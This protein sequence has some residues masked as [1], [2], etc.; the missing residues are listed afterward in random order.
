MDFNT[1]LFIFLFLPLTFFVYF[2]AA[3]RGRVIVAVAASLLFYAWGQP[4]NLALVLG[5]LLLTF[6]IAKRAAAPR[7]L[8]TGILLN[9]AVLVFFKAATTYWFDDLAYPLG[10]SYVSFQVI[11]YLID[12][13]RGRVEAESDLPRFA[14]YVLLF[15]KLLAGPITRYASLRDELANPQV[16][17][18]GVTTGI[19]RFILGFAKKALIADTLARIVTPVFAL[20][21]P[22]IAPGLA[23][24]VLIAYTLQLYFDFSG[25]TDMAI[26]LG[27]ML[28]FT[29]VENFDHPY[30]AK[31][32]GD[33]WRRW[34]ISLSSWFRD[35]VFYPLERRRIKIIGQPLNILAVFLL[36]GL[37]HGLTLPFAAW[38]LL[39]GLAIVFEN[40]RAGRWLKSAWAP[41]QH[42]YALS[43][44]LPGW[45]FFRSPSVDFALEFL[46]RLAGWTG[47]LLPL[48][49]AE[50]SPLPL[51][52][53]S[54]WLALVAGVVFSLNTGQIFHL[55]Y[56]KQIENLPEV[57]KLALQAISDGILLILLAASIAAAVSGQFAPGI[58]GGF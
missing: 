21:S 45:V 49:F 51:V 14:A 10:L 55:P 2:L 44:I 28:G 47:G 58:Y 11:S 48:P 5:I 26:G 54:V 19:R 46:R 25:Y 37:W 12:V 36:T 41:V 18:D 42:L 3:P 35:Y 13:N 27:R 17:L 7:W 31:S 4:Q 33:F 8:W 6:F 23:W 9:L 32:I 34:H 57:G 43:V 1:P 20:A 52:E 50:T 22:Q 29:F 30:T 40:S 53:P 24:L 56:K 38:G 15:P 39:H 16:S